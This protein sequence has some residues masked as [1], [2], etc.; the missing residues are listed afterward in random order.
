MVRA[1]LDGRKTITRRLVKPQPEHAVLIRTGANDVPLDGCYWRPGGP[2]VDGP[3]RRGMRLWL[4][5]TFAEND[6]QLF[7]RATY[8]PEHVAPGEEIPDKGNVPWK[9]SIFMPRWASRITL[10]VLSVRVERLNQITADDVVLEGFCPSDVPG[11]GSDS[12]FIQAFAKLWDKLN[13]DHKW[14]SDPFVWRV[15]FKRIKP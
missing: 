11:I 14:E 7:Y 6:G 12:S 13:P 1:L 3:Y 4:R 8:G 9:P 15:E 2:V 10:E 5:E